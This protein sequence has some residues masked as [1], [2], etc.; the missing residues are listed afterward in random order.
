MTMSRPAQQHD[1]LG[2]EDD[3]TPEQK[4]LWRGRFCCVDC[5][6]CTLCAGEYYMVKHAVWVASGMGPIDGMLCLACLECRIGRALTKRD[7]R[8]PKPRLHAWR[9]HLAAR[10]TIRDRQPAQLDLLDAAE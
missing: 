5:S 7:F 6:K 10:A 9:R 8:S 1:H 3:L 2:D 4:E